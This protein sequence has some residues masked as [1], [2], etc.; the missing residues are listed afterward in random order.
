MPLSTRFHQLVL[1]FLLLPS[2]WGY[3]Q[4]SEID[5]L[6]GLLRDKTIHDT[7]RLSIINS[8]LGSV[9][10][11]DSMSVHYNSIV[12]KIV[13]KNLKKK[14]LSSKLRDTY[15]TYAAYWYCDKA[16]EIFSAKNGQQVLNYYDKAISLFKKLGMEEERWITVTN[17]GN[18]LRK[19]NAPK[20]AIGCYFQSLKHLEAN[21][22]I[23]GVAATNS[24]I[25]QV[26]DDQGNYSQAI[27]QYRKA[28][29]TYC[30][31]RKKTQQD[32]FEMAVVLHN[33]GFAYYNKE[34]YIEAKNYYFQSLKIAEENAFFNH[35]AFDANKIGDIYLDQKN[36]DAALK[37]FEKGLV[38]A[39][40]DRSTTS[41]LLSIG[42]LYIEKG[43]LKK[44]LSYSNK[45][46]K[47]ALESHDSGMLQRSYDN[48]YRLY[49]VMNRPAEALKMY[50][51]YIR[52]KNIFN[53][54]EAKN[55]LEQQELKYQFEKK[56][57]LNRIRHEKK[58]ASLRIANE[59]KTARKDKVLYLLIGLAVI[60]L[61]SF[62]GVYYYFRQKNIRSI[63]KNTEL[64]QKLLLTQMN[65]HFIF[66]SVDT[67]QSLIYNK[68]DKEAISYLTKFSKLTRQILEYSNENYILLS[69]ELTMLENYLGIQKLLYNNNFN[70][71]IAVGENIDPEFILVPPMLTQPFIENAIKHGLSNKL[72]GGLIHI[73]YVMINDQ[74]CFQVTDN[75]TGLTT[76]QLSQKSLAT[77]ITRERLVHLREKGDSTIHIL[78]ITDASNS[79]LGVKTSFEIPFIYNQ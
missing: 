37:L 64:K 10:A 49:K 54:E 23:I 33:I 57:L 22:D 50:E 14:N 29:T 3:S 66:N 44:A 13:F 56:E 40:D 72:E 28:L 75:G 1:C 32:L 21:G 18:I 24:S 4:Q 16:S 71:T 62:L 41:L 2:F 17:K 34:N 46:L 35:A 42:E 74:L 73:Q 58:V 8:I 9:K 12:G 53:E 39:R 60:L 65:P 31:I 25:G 7:T 78:N 38:Y 77:Q 6:K 11:G 27:N 45:G 48:L 70:F 55:T 20:A 19:M 76:N 47:R 5:S 43:D 26:Y 15:E 30:T 69:E 68:Q 79:I 59:Q 52:E 51:L 63:H 36:Y 61:I 67:I